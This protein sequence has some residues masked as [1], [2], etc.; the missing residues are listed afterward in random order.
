MPKNGVSTSHE[1]PLAGH[2]GHRKTDL[3]LCEHF[4]GRL[5]LKTLGIIIDRLSE[6]EAER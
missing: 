4:S 1:S 6:D 5:S 3:R 2:F